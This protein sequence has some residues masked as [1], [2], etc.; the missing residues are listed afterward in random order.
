MGAKMD[1]LFVLSSVRVGDG[2]SN[3][4][5]ILNGLAVAKSDAFDPLEASR[6][7]HQ[8]GIEQLLLGVMPSRGWLKGEVAADGFDPV[9]LRERAVTEPSTEGAQLRLSDH[10]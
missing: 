7:L 4:N 5:R 1:N 8:L 3:S 6:E 10:D 9:T 2:E